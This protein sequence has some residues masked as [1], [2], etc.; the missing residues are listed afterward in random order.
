MAKECR[1]IGGETGLLTPA[2]IENVTPDPLH[3]G[4]LGA[5]GIMFDP[6]CIAILVEQFFFLAGRVS[7]VPS[8]DCL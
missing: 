2:V 3:V 1:K 6:N 8:L 5:G 4:F 7:G